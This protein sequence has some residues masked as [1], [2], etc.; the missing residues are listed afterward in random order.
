M[1]K[2]RAPLENNLEKLPVFLGSLK[3]V[4]GS[5]LTARQEEAYSL[6]GTAQ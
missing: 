4:Y 6:F 2:L 5:P 3:G 1:V